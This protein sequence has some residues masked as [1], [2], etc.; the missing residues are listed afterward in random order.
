MADSPE[1]PQGPPAS[2]AHQRGRTAVFAVA[3]VAIFIAGLAIGVF[4]LSAWVTPGE[5]SVTPRVVVVGPNAS[6]VSESSTCDGPQYS[7][8][9]Y[10]HC[11][12]TIACSERGPGNFILNN[13]SAPAASNLAVVPVPPVNVPCDTPVTL[14]VAAQLGYSGTVAVYLYSV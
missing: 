5:I 14:Q 12:A 8:D 3:L 13:V 9:G 11:S 2:S 6:N 7:Y 10:F 1:G 4:V